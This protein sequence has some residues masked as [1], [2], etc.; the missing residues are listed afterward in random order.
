VLEKLNWAETGLDRYL[1]RLGFCDSTLAENT[2]SLRGNNP[3]AMPRCST[4]AVLHF[5]IFKDSFSEAA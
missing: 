1:Y 5:F 2:A 3:A 4:G